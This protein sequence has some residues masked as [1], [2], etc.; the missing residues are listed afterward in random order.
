LALLAILSVSAKIK[1]AKISH[2]CDL[3][4]FVFHSDSGDKF[5][6]ESIVSYLEPLPNSGTLGSRTSANLSE[7]SGERRLGAALGRGIE[8]EIKME[9]CTASSSTGYTASRAALWLWVAASEFCTG[10][11]FHTRRGNADCL[12]PRSTSH[13]YGCCGW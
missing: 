5:S 7:R 11:G 3:G 4:S 2:A 6:P 9:L 1:A 8:D 12:N 13:G 10:A